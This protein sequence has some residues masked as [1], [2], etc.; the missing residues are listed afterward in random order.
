MC[1]GA[2]VRGLAVGLGVAD[3][4]PFVGAAAAVP[5]HPLW[6]I[7]FAA[8]AAPSSAH[9]GLIAGIWSE[10]FDHLAVFQNFIIM[11]L[12][13]LSGVFYSIH[14]LPSFWQGLSHFNPF[15][16]MIDGF[17]YG[18]FGIADVS[19]WRSLAVVVFF[20]VALSAIALRML[21]TGYKLRQ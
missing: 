7:G 17:R 12:T 1:F 4:L 16:Y 2:M 3:H 15:F 20:V 8:V 14:S 9:L 18:F 11:P 13:F 10:K 5:Q 21:A 6:V 19:P